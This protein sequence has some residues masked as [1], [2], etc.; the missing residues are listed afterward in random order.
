MRLYSIID[1]YWP[2]SFALH[3]TAHALILRVD[4]EVVFEVGI[5]FTS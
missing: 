4:I 5:V 2:V 3:P 1:P